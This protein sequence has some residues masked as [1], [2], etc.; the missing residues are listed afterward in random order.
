MQIGNSFSYAFG[1]LIALIG[2]GAMVLVLRWAYA[3]GSSVV[4]APARAGR[5]EEY[6]LLVCVASPGDYVHGEMI[7]RSLED[8]GIKANLVQTLDG[9]KVMV[10]PADK[11]TALT[12]LRE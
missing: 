6:G 4:A 10:W 12:L 8:R 1:P 11:D 3:R 5:A 7:R 2:V 9:P